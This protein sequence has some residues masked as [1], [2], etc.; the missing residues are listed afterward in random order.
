MGRMEKRGTRGD[1]SYQNKDHSGKFKAGGALVFEMVC[2]GQF[3]RKR[4][5]SGL[6]PRLG[7]VNRLVLLVEDLIEKII[8]QHNV[9]IKT[10]QTTQSYGAINSMQQT[11]IQGNSLQISKT[12]FF[13]N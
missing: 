5:R 12:E 1:M 2:S 4:H 9:T 6:N 7:S 3:D 13:Q 10:N 8:S 11:S